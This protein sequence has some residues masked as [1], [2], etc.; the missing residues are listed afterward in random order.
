MSILDRDFFDRSV[1]EV[2]T[3]LIGCGVRFNGVAGVIVETE[4]YQRDD[5]ACHAFV[6]L[7]ARTATL[8]GPPGT[9][10]RVPLLRHPQPSQLRG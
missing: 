1:H 3:E 7:T 9:R 5:P 2:A 8:F 10:L 6:G 4:S